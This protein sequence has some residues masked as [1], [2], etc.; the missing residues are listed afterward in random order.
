MKQRSTEEV[1]FDHLKL[2]KKQEDYL[3]IVKNYDH[4]VVIFTEDGVRTGTKAVEA[5][6][7]QLQEN[8]PEANYEYVSKLIYGEWAF[9]IWKAISAKGTLCNGVD[10]FMIRNGKV[11]VQTIYYKLENQ[12]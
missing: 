12:D 8:F 7:R 6:T 10:S 9:L 2:R 4:E 3:D 11:C 5:C 1:F